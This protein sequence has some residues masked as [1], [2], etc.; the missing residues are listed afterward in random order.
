[1]YIVYK[2]CLSHQAYTCMNRCF[3][4]VH[5]LLDGNQFPAVQKKGQLYI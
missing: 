5:S 2:Y 3:P 1:M 4:N